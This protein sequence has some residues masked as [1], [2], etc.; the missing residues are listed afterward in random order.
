MEEI[1]TL[2]DY[3]EAL[4]LNITSNGTLSTYLIK[5][6]SKEFDFEGIDKIDE[7]NIALL[8]KETPEVEVKSFDNK[9]TLLLEFD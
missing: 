7:F 2:Y 8:E 5:E 6:L 1:I 4:S 9:G 3:L